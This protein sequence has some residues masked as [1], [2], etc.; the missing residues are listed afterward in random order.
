ME[1]SKP[2]PSLSH[3]TTA[4]PN[5]HPPPEHA[6]DSRPRI[7]EAMRTLWLDLLP[8]DSIRLQDDFFALGGSS[9]SALQ[10]VAAI[11]SKFN[12][13]M[14]LRDLLQTPT[15]HSMSESLWKRLDRQHSKAGSFEK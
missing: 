14:S 9:L 8:T 12:I 6:G 11:E 1:Q 10:L 2:R 7:E 15:L 4:S 3:T 5:H 13:R